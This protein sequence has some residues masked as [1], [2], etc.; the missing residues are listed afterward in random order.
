VKAAPFSYVRPATV[1]DA[2]A[3]L[4]ADDSKVVAGGQSLVPVLAMRLAR[5]GTLVDINAVDGLGTIAAA[6]GRLRIGATA[7]QR[8]VERHDRIATVPLLAQ[9]LPLVGHRELRSRGTVCGSLAHADPAAELPAAATC[10]DATVEVTGAEGTRRIPA[11]E[12]FTGAMTTS[13]GA[14]ELLV[15]VEFPQARPG[16]GFGF[17]E[18]ARRHGDFALAGVAV[19]VEAADLNTDERAEVTCFG[20][21]D[22]P[23]LR[24]FS[25]QLRG[26]VDRVGLDAP[27]EALRRVLRDAALALAD[28]VVQTGGDA[29]GSTTYRRRL[30]AALTAREVARAHRHA[31]HSATRE[32]RS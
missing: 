15:A 16:Q 32:A 26:A 13:V 29:H 21:S 8:A 28:D 22:T 6:D 1:D 20:V 4:S 5:P 30:V 12:L 11:R 14:E 9:A 7:R 23:V 19:C 2:I 24:D 10:L 18:V 25:A 31:H 27:E 3:E 17:A